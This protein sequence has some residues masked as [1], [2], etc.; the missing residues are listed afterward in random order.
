MEKLSYG[1]VDV[2]KD[3]LDVVV[4]PE[5]QCSAVRNDV[6]GWAELVEQLRDFSIAAIGLRGEGWLRRQSQ[7]RGAGLSANLHRYLQQGRL[8]QAL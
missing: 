6:A 1:G 7:E 8:C 3:R 5:Q 4:L 2:S